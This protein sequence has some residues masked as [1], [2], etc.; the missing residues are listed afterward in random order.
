MSQLELVD[1]TG[2]RVL[3]DI[4]H[5]LE[6]RGVTVLIKGVRPEYEELFRTVGVLDYSATTTTSSICPT[7]SSTR[8]TISAAS[9]PVEPRVGCR[10]CRR[11][12]QR[13]VAASFTHG[14]ICSAW[15]RPHPRRSAGAPSDRR[16]LQLRR[17]AG[18]H[19]EERRDLRLRTLVRF[20]ASRGAL[21]TFIDLIARRIT[22]EDHAEQPVRRSHRGVRRL[23]HRA[24]RP[25][26]RERAVHRLRLPARTQAKACTASS[27][28]STTRLPLQ[29][30]PRC[31]TPGACSPVSNT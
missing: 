8:A 23:A 9:A 14:S 1:A 4:V 25:C 20:A 30:I 15:R 29:P 27:T 12:Q 11:R 2:A 24:H 10:G 28:R 26:E 21:D 31:R 13:H 7:R 3:T 17:R 18:P 5:A 6:R 19:L 22:R 16:R